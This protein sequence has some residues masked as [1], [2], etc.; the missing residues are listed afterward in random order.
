[1]LE[2]TWK[3]QHRSSVQSSSLTSAMEPQTKHKP[4]GVLMQNL[5]LELPELVLQGLV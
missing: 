2:H 3:E 1:M 4:E 5:K